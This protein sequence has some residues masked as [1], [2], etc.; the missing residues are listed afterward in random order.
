MQAVNSIDSSDYS[1]VSYFV[2][3]DLPGAPATPTLETST[4]S[5]ITIAWN[6]PTYT[7]GV[8]LTGYRVYMND[9]ISDIW[10]MIYDGNNY[11]STLT[12]TQTGLNAGQFYRF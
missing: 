10:V 1:D 2:C 5:S 3:A 8:A 7:G 6:P 4:S 12:F 11:P 9:L